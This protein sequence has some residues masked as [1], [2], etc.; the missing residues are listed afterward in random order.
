MIVN[1]QIARAINAHYFNDPSVRLGAGDVL[2]ALLL[3]YLLGAAISGRW[4]LF[5]RAS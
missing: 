2:A 5:A 4:R 3:T 1:Y